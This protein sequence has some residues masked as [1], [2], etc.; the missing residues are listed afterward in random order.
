MSETI[1]I[2]LPDFSGTA[3]LNLFLRRT[4]TGAMLNTG[5]DALSESPA[6]SGRFVG[7]LAESRVGLGTLVASV[8][9]GTESADNLVWDGWLAEAASLVTDTYGPAE[10]DSATQTQIDNILD[11][12]AWMLADATGAIA[13]PQSATATAILTVF[14]STYTV[15]YAGLTATGVRTAPTLS[16]V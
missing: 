4:D 11:G 3:T 15:Q 12:V 14:G 7:T 8:C 13:A 16:K 5:G 9:D 1:S 6:S 10:L 2:H